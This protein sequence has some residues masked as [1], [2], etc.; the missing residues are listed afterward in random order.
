MGALSRNRTIPAI[1]RIDASK[2]G[3]VMAIVG[4]ESDRG[5]ALAGR[6]ITSM[7]SNDVANL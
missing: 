7:L 1:C 4:V 3:A 5:A 6:P 2:G